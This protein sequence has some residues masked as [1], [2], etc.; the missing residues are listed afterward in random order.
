MCSNKG[1]VKEKKMDL[2]KMGMGSRLGKRKD[3]GRNLRWEVGRMEDGEG[4]E[5]DS[6]RR[7]WGEG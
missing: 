2:G 3:E 5:A 1:V 6:R 4:K 7:K